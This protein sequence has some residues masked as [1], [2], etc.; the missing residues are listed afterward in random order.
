MSATVNCCIGHAIVAAKKKKNKSRHHYFINSFGINKVPLNTISVFSLV[1]TRC[2]CNFRLT[3]TLAACSILNWLPRQRRQPRTVICFGE[4]HTLGLACI[5]CARRTH[6][7][8]SIEQAVE[9]FI[10]V[11]C[12]RR[13][14]ESS[15]TE[16]HSAGGM[17][18]EV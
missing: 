13:F 4:F 3:Q 9:I 15:S 16:Y 1:A 12:D 17:G 2:V 7:I 14:V 18:C 10:Y 5:A 8:I 11:A 6:S